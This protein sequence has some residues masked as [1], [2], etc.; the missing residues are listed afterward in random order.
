M[1]DLGL[2]AQKRVVD[3]VEQDGEIDPDSLAEYLEQHFSAQL[4]ILETLN[5]E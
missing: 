1:H 5:D 3:G 2:I 4:K